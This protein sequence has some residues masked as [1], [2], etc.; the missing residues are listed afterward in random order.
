MSLCFVVVSV[1]L[2]ILD[3]ALWC[4][5]PGLSCTPLKVNQLLFIYGLIIKH[6]EC[7]LGKRLHRDSNKNLYNDFPEMM[8]TENT[9]SLASSPFVMIKGFLEIIEEIGLTERA[10]W[11]KR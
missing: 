1:C 11:E 5:V 3:K 6:G 8:L 7:A 9:V 2:S 10:E 4:T